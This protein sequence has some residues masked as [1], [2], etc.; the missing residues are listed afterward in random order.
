MTGDTSMS[1]VLLVHVSADAALAARLSVDLRMS[2]VN[3]RIDEWEIEAGHSLEN[4][5]ARGLLDGGFMAL[6]LSHSSA[7]SGWLN[8]DMQLALEQ[9]AGA[10]GIDTVVLAADDVPVPDRLQGFSRFNTGEAYEQGMEALV[11][12]VAPEDG[13]S[14]NSRAC[15]MIEHGYIRARRMEPALHRV[16]NLVINIAGGTLRRT[17]AGMVGALYTVAPDRSIQAFCE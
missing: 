6:L 10:R 17:D 12:K 2:G 7:A 15:A 9:A 11:A 4:V 5:L 8:S 1:A 14:P 3:V 16:H 13:N